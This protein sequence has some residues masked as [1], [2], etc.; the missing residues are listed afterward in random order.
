[1]ATFNPERQVWRLTATAS[2]PGEA[3]RRR[4]RDFHAPD[5][6]AG[7]RA[8]EAAEVRFRDEI[9][10]ELETTVYAGT[11]AAA[12]ADWVKR[13]REDWSPLNVKHVERALRAHVNPTLGPIALEAVSAEDVEN[14]YADWSAAGYAKPTRRRWHGMVRAI[15][16]EAIRLG[17]LTVDPMV[18]VKPAG[19]TKADTPPTIPSPDDIEAAIEAAPTAMAG[20]FFTM[21]ARTGARRDSILNLRWRDVDLDAATLHFTVTKEDEPYT[22]AIDDGLVAELRSQRREAL[23]TAMALGLGRRIGDLY[24]FSSDGGATPWGVSWPSHA[25]RKAADK[26]GL[27][28]VRLHDLRHFHASRLLKARF[29]HAEVAERLG[30]TEAN[31]IRTYSHVVDRDADRRAADVVGALFSAAS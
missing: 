4:V 18:R 13:N 3:R 16:S 20:R 7:R 9:A 19:R 11:F 2:R 29:S 25:W 27:Y 5:T 22:V 6:R 17:R 30:C 31:V 10:A 8:A 1:M 14:L 24:L 23:E 21:A 26:V 28:E 15:F 12:A